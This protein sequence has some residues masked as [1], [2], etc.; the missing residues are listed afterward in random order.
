VEIITFPQAC[1][2]VGLFA[3][4]QAFCLIFYRL[5]PSLPIDFLPLDFNLD[6]KSVEFSK[7]RTKNVSSLRTLPLVPVFR[8]KLLELKKQQEANRA[9]FKRSYR[10]DFLNYIYVDEMGERI[11][12][13]YITTRFPIILEQNHM[14]IIRFHDLRHSCASLLLVAGVSMKAIQEWLGHN[15]FATTADIY[16]HL[17]FKSKITSANAMIQCLGMSTLE[18]KTPQTKEQASKSVET[19][20]MPV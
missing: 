16:A 9:L 8:E 19:L 17:S 1:L 2:G 3:L 10:T 15:T 12:P 13:G 11:K 7:D 6:G 5:F 14:R 18:G 4:F 20:Q